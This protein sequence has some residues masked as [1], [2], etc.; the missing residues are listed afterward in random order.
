MRSGRHLAFF[1]KSAGICGWIGVVRPVRIGSDF[2]DSELLEQ[3]SPG[4]SLLWEYLKCKRTDRWNDSNVHCC[5]VDT[6]GDYTWNDWTSKQPIREIEGFQRG[7]GLPTGLLLDLDGG[8]LSVYQNGQKL[9]TLKDGL[10]GEYCWYHTVGLDTSISIERGS[11][12][13]E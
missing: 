8:T 6:Q 13:D 4:A 9:A 1:T 11:S 3:F 10:S 12:S 7:N 5:A 2:D